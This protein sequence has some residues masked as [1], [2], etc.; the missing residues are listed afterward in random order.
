MVMQIRSTQSSVAVRAMTGLQGNLSRLGELQERLSSG[1]QLSRPSDSPTGT[2]SAMQLRAQHRAAEQHVRNADDGLG[3]LSTIDDALTSGLSQ[4]RRVRDLT[5]QGMSSGAAGAPETR[6]A[7]AVEVDNIRE[8]MIELANTRYLNRPVFGGTTTGAQGYNSSGAYL[9]DSGEVFRTVGDGSRIRV[10]STGEQVFGTGN[11][12]L[13]TVL[14]DVATEL[15][16]G[17]SGLGS[18]LERLDTAIN[19]MTSQLADVGARY[20]RVEQM[21]QKADESLLT[22]KSQLSDVEDID[23]PKTIMDLKLQQTAYEA[24]LAATAKVIQPSLIDFLR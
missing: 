18:T 16:D 4:A 12:Q 8:S 15:R 13:F 22:L 21:R 19:R 6:E 17:S 23:L 20:N 14:G 1:R 3:W 7:L 11:T 5:L 24:A 2:V 9:G 10:D